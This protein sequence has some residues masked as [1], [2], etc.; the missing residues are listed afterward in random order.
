[1]AAV[2]VKWSLMDPESTAAIFVDYMT[3]SLT[4]DDLTG[5]IKERIQKYTELCM[6]IWLI[7]QVIHKDGCCRPG[8]VK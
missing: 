8:A 4:N 3:L 6:Y 7:S 5:G 1:M 2:A